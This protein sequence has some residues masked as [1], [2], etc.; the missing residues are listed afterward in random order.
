MAGGVHGGSSMHGGGHAWWGGA[1]EWRGSC[2]AR[3]PPAPDTMINGRSMSG[4]YSSYWN[5]FLFFNLGIIKFNFN[6]SLAF[7]TGNLEG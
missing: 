4:Q 7:S 1:H 5:A 2:M 6:A 3:M